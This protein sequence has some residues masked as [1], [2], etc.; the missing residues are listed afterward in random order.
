MLHF[1]TLG[2]QYKNKIYI[3]FS[4]NSSK[5]NLF[6]LIKNYEYNINFVFY[7]FLIENNV[8]FTINIY[9]NYIKIIYIY[10]YKIIL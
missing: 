9:K 1:N 2:I 8:Y 6:R 7:M 5:Q 3:L 10:L 4:S